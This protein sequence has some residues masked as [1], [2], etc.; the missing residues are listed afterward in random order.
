MSGFYLIEICN[1]INSNIDGK[2]RL[3][4]ELADKEC[5]CPKKLKF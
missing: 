1:V 4:T 3:I 5:R 2:I